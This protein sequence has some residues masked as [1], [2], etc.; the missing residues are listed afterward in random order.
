MILHRPDLLDRTHE[1]ISRYSRADAD[2]YVEL[3][4]RA[5]DLEQV[6]AT[7]LYNIPQPG[8]LDDQAAMIQAAFG[9]LGVGPQFLMKSPKH[10]IDEFFETP[11]CARAPLPGMCRVGYPI[12]GQGLG[13][14][15]LVFVMW[16][17]G[18][19]NLAHGGTHTLAKAMTQACY[20][21]GVDLLENVMVEQVIVDDGRAVGVKRVGE[22]RATK[23]VASNADLRQT[24][25]DLVGEENLSALWVKRARSYRYGPSH[26]LGTPCFCLYEPPHYKSARWDPAIDRCFYTMVGFDGPEDTVRYIRDTYM[27]KRSQARCG[28]LGQQPL[29]PVASTARPARG[30]GVVLPPESKHAY[31]RG[32]GRGAC[33]LQ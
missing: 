11:D 13:A 6:F 24:L 14:G 19:W 29:G 2:M 15:F 23:V 25:L 17:L 5:V 26:V 9:D 4:H 28:N 22:I 12:D 21:E 8:G 31:H 32:V 7:G 20:R 18:N 33:N 1:S 30:D 3:K 27:G 10:V 16:T